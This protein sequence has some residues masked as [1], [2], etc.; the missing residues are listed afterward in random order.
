MP[1]LARQS[2]KVSILVATAVIAGQN[3]TIQYLEVV[4]KYLPPGWLGLLFTAGLT[5]LLYRLVIQFYEKKAWRWFNRK[6]VLAGKWKHTL[7]PADL[8]PNNDREGEFVILQTAF[9]TKIVGGKNYDQKTGRISHWKSLAVFDDELPERSLWIIY[10]IERGE[11]KLVK[12]EGEIDRGLI[13]VHLDVDEGT[14]RITKMSGNYWD[15]G[16]SQHKGSF[17][18][19][20][21]GTEAPDG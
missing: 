3:L 19:G 1:N 21:M 8:N 20:L 7:S 4:K 9:E 14:G 17:E 18:A 11:G 6:I 2:Y 16:R 12:G 15:A 5:S 13:R 10:Q